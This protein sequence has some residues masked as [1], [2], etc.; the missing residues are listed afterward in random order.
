MNV[1]LKHL[2]SKG[3]QLKMFSFKCVKMMYLNGNFS[4]Q[5]TALDRA[6]AA[7]G[8]ARNNQKIE[9][10]YKTLRKAIALLPNQ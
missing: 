5:D 6:T 10:L 3:I 4:P 2:L 7:F 1:P 9:D 8:L